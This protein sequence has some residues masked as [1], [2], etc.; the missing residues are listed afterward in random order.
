MRPLRC[1]LG[2]GRGTGKSIKGIFCGL[3]GGVVKW[4]KI[5][6]TNTVLIIDN[7]SCLEQAFSLLSLRTK[8]CKNVVRRELQPGCS[9]FEASVLNRC[10]FL[11]I[12][13]SMATE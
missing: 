12:G 4:N 10:S 9:V 11:I 7:V 2:R 6:F 1:I 13:Y 3:G 8:N 5:F